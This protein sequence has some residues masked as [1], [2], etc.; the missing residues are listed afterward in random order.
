MT[1]AT[2]NKKIS[3]SNPKDMTL[4]D[5][6]AL[7]EK[8]AYLDAGLKKMKEHL[9]LYVELNGAVE[10]GDVVWDKFPS[11]SY[12]WAT[13]AKR[14]F[15]E[16]IAIEGKNPWEYLSF[17]ASDQKKLGWGENVISQYA[18]VRINHSFK[19]KKKD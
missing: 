11:Q 14:S 16:M 15:A 10:A 4:E 5:A 7:A 8:I 12:K 17:T 6:Q 18:E 2:E 3:L 9:K 1:N 19:S 13:E